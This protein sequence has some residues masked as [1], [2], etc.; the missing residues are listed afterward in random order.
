ML[1]CT[2]YTRTYCKR[3]GGLGDGAHRKLFPNNN[4]YWENFWKKRWNTPPLFERE[5][6]FWKG[7]VI[8]RSGVTE[9][10]IFFQISNIVWSRSFLR[11]KHILINEALRAGPH[12]RAPSLSILDI[13]RL[14]LKVNWRRLCGTKRGCTSNLTCIFLQ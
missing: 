13:L 11:R 14:V 12:K 6:N 9:F 8:N 4:T 3:K 5:K 2:I 10:I 1:I 7:V